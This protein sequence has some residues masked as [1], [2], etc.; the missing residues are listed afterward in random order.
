[1][2]GNHAVVLDQPHYGKKTLYEC[3]NR[4]CVVDNP[5]EPIPKY[6][7]LRHFN[8]AGWRR[9]REHEEHFLCPTCSGEGK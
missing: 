1:M 6:Y 8:E 7:S 5:D 2:Y 4:E 3:C 9:T